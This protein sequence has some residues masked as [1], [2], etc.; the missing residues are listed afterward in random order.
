MPHTVNFTLSGSYT[1][2]SKSMECSAHGTTASFDPH[3]TSYLAA[4]PVS[5]LRKTFSTLVSAF[6]NIPCMEPS[7][8][9]PFVLDE[10]RG[11]YTLG[12]VRWDHEPMVRLHQTLD[13]TSMSHFHN[14]SAIVEL[15]RCPDTR[16]SEDLVGA[17]ACLCRKHE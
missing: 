9:S 5:H 3:K 7:Q 8:A 15:G 10:R 6:T 11:R 17:S 12:T 1:R 16:H 4:L 13:R 2:L 14:K